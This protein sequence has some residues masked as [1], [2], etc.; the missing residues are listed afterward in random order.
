M[1]GSLGEPLCPFL[2]T[3]IEAGCAA[4]HHD[5]KQC[6][7]LAASFKRSHARRVDR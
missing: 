2:A 7:R 6:Q 1:R 3:H 5:V 4:Y